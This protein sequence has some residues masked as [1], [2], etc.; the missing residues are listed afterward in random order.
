[1]LIEPNRYLRALLRDYALRGGRVVIRKFRSAAELLALDEPLVM[2]CA[3]LGAKGLS[4]L[5]PQPAVD[6][7]TLHGAHDMFLRSDGIVL[8][9][10]FQHGN[11]DLQ[12]NPATEADVLADHAAFFSHMH[13]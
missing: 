3:G 2:N 4:V 8:G 9:G 12:P 5:A 10:T 6:Y 1:M 7:I 11:A 13:V